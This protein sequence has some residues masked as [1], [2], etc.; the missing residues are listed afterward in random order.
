M[1]MDIGYVLF[2][3]A[4]AVVTLFIAINYLKLQAES[5]SLRSQLTALE[6]EYSTLK[7]QNDE[8]YHRALS[9]VDLE[10]V[11]DTAINKLGMVYASSGQ[12]VTYNDQDGDYVRQYEDVPAE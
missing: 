5:T 6:S 8:E 4:A 2:L 3:T 7:L 1:Q 11:R 12:V 10:Y 9:S